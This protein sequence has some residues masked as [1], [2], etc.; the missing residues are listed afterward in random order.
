MVPILLL[1]ALFPLIRLHVGPSLYDRVA[2]ASSACLIAALA[3]A[4]LSV[5][6]NSNASL[7][8]A[9]GLVGGVIVFNAAA[10]KFF[11]RRSFQA[12]QS[13]LDPSLASRDVARD[14]QGVR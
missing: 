10:Y 3:C 9:F 2:A 4:A 5:A 1:A 8:V 12:A 14:E 11:S 7:D 13:A 6:R